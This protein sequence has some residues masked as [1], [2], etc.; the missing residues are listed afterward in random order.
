[1]KIFIVKSL[2]QSI[3]LLILIFCTSIL[4][5]QLNADFTPDQAG[6]C[7]P[8]KVS[9]KN[10]TTGASA[11]AV[12]KWDLG[13]NNTSTLSNP[14]ATYREEKNYTVTLTVTDGGKTSAKTKQI[15]VYKKPAVDFSASKT[16]GCSPLS[17]DFT[18]KSTA[19]DGSIASYF[20]DFGDGTTQQTEG[21]Q[22]SHTYNSPTKAPVSL[23]VT[24]SYGCFNTLQKPNMVEVLPG[25]KPSFT[26]DKTI[27]CKTT[28]AVK[29]N[30]T[31]TGPADITYLWDFGD[32][33][34]S[35]D[36]NPSHVY[37]Q[38]GVF[39]IKLTVSSASGC[40]DTY[41]ETNY[42]NVANFSTDFSVPGLIC[43]NTNTTFNSTGTAANATSIWEFD[44]NRYSSYGNSIDF[45]FV[46]AGAH[47]VKLTNTYG[48]CQESIS[49]NITVKTSP[50]LNGFIST[51]SKPCGAPVTVSFKD[52]AKAAVKWLWNFDYPY[53]SNT[54]T[55]K[56]PSFTYNSEG[57]YT[58]GLTVTNAEGC[59]ATAAQT[60]N[61]S[62]PNISINIL[63][64][65]ASNYLS[66]CT[67]LTIKFAATPAD[68][69]TEYKWDFG[70][71]T[72]SAEAQPAHVFNK[73]GTFTVKL[74]Y[75]TAAGCKG[76]VVS[77]NPIT[78]SQKPDFDYASLQGTTICAN[79]PVTFS[80]TLNNNVP[81]TNWYWIFGDNN[82]SND[83][84][85]SSANHLYTKD[86]TYTIS[87]IAANGG[88]T[89]TVTKQN[90]LKVLPPFPKIVSAS[91]TCEGTRGTV[92]FF[93]ETQKAISGTWNFGD[94][95][96]APLQPGQ[97]TISHTY[98]KT[99]SYKVALTA[100]NG[101]CSVTD[102]IN[103]YVLLKQKPLLT[104]KQPEI[105]G[106]DKNDIK[107]SNLI[108]NPVPS[109]YYYSY[110]YSITS[111]QYG[112]GTSYNGVAS[113]S[114]YYWDTVFNGSVQNLE[115]GKKDLRAI[116]T[117]GYFG[118]NDTSN[119]IPLKIKGPQANFGITTNNVCYKSPVVFSDSSK[120]NNNVAIKSWEWSYGDG[121]AKTFSNN[122]AVKYI[123]DNPGSF[124]VT[125][126]VT[127]AEG[128]SATTANYTKTAE[129]KGPKAAFS[130]YPYNVSPNT[131][132]S[133]YNNSNSY[134][135]YN[136]QY[137]W[138]LP[139]G[140]TSS[141]YYPTYTFNEAGANTVKLF[142]KDPA[143]GCADTAIQI[144]NVK[145]VNAGFTYTTT[146][147][148]NNSCPPVVAKFT[149]TSLN[150]TS[151]SWDF[152]DGSHADNQNYP[153]HTYYNPGVYYLTLYI[154]GTDGITDSTTDSI[155]IKGPYARLHA[156][157]LSGCI[158]QTVTLSAEVK[159]AVSYTWDFGDG[160][161]KDTKDT[162]AVHQYSSPGIYIP[163]LILKD[164]SGC[165]GTSEINNK[166]V[167]DTL[168]IK[169]S[170]NLQIIC[171]SSQAFFN[172]EIYSL[173]EEQMQ[174]TLQYK[175]EF[176]TGNPKD[177][178]N[179]KNP[180]FYYTKPG[181][182]EVKLHVASPHGCAKETIDS[183]QVLPRARGKIQS[184]PEICQGTTAKFS[185]TADIN[186]NV[187]WK[188]IFNNG[189]T[190]KAQNPP[191]QS[192]NDEG[193]FKIMLV[194]NNAGCYDTVSN[195]LVVRP[196]PDINLTPEKTAICLGKSLQL[197]AGGGDVYTWRADSGLSDY[198]IAQPVATPKKNTIYSVEVTNSFGCKNIDSAIIGVAAP[199]KVQV[200]AQPF[201]CQ[202]KELQLNATGAFSYKWINNTTAISNT[203]IPNPVVTPS[204]P[205]V[206]T[207][208]GYDAYNCFTDTQ[209]VKVNVAPLPTINAGPDL[210]VFTGSDVQLQA[211][212]SSDVTKYTWFPAD[213]LSCSDCPSPV[214][215]PRANM[216]YIITGTTQHGCSAADTINIKLL[217]NQGKVYIPTAFTPNGDYKNDLFY[218][219]GRGVKIIKSLKI[220]NRFGEAIFE[221]T[222]FQI[223]DPSSGWDGKYKGIEASTGAY[224]YFTEMVCDNGEMFSFKGT[225][226]VVR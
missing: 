25:I 75:V 196:K 41:T 221:K 49:K 101:Q 115:N 6:G 4:S 29:F 150:S 61:I 123:Y 88:C 176:G 31:S 134:N 216:S 140:S 3:L 98:A 18:D 103:A 23:T 202:G 224:V 107:I 111:F 55:V 94:G 116:L 79:S 100:V 208:V 21:K 83:N 133:F 91:N 168:R 223:E 9:F 84:N 217:C 87:L 2:L 187:D 175:W 166:I 1:M 22:Y 180:Y 47:T 161:L 8:L 106:S 46:A 135:S 170:K 222:N 144:I 95:T 194:V 105:C 66:G 114:E 56:E 89:D 78:V 145:N 67:G 130:Y 37:N 33:K 54:S 220:F 189:N 165:S 214:S 102:S 44:N 154:T 68:D 182:Y 45:N 112:D 36:K 142:A 164:A 139:N 12:Y 188:W 137:A 205:A 73:Q 141:D 58:T 178:S 210:Q 171:D 51:L 50:V 117:S 62:K 42:I 85:T 77:N 5:A 24:N 104:S 76:E 19:G 30:N 160:S 131:T 197:Q 191:V 69:I 204:A 72:T 219:K 113:S 28:D 11:A 39:T 185:G 174:Q 16:Y 48:T 86:T 119:I 186:N 215:S 213:Y 65:N 163:A 209:S 122:N 126:K 92:T 132:V 181:K 162:F 7:S 63:S 136:S 218:I 27:L 206:Y 179:L 148:N 226:M 20:W 124:Y 80:V 147:V 125:L 43:Q 153:S 35:A 17:V 203:Q 59:S 34:T 13:N 82:Y 120:G 110:P 32:G 26:A 195:D 152:G 71:G 81:V 40:S 184:P 167:I 149:N 129:V 53:S 190:S 151:A 127:D 93:H 156:D 193:T 74:N 138:L 199:F 198:T 172:P 159:N 52:T 183:I 201:I 10:T 60:F 97:S 118:C 169:I 70:D 177:T 121:T 99:G 225:V 200:P 192:Y 143:T 173:A 57:Y 15:T 38:K 128:C 109:N 146:Y 211:S 212:V 96:S 14:G 157:I 207:V 90:Y 155:T 64:S 108:K 158:S